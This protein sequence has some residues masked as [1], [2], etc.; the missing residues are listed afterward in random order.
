MDDLNALRKEL[1]MSV[2][3]ILV[4]DAQNKYPEPRIFNPNSNDSME[5]QIEEWKSKSAE[6]RGFDL[7]FKSI[8]GYSTKEFN[9]E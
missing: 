6:Q 4:K 5:K 3:R 9:Y 8:T 7:C 2:F 1:L